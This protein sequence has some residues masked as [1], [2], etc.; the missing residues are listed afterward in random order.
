LI[1]ITGVA[2]LIAVLL[3]R[4]DKRVSKA[5]AKNFKGPRDLPVFGSA[6]EF[7]APNEDLMPILVSV[8]KEFGS[9]FRVWLGNQPYVVLCEGSHVEVRNNIGMRHSTCSVYHVSIIYY[10][11]NNILF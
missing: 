7:L 4:R 3:T 5:F 9:G 1:F 2:F 10:F 11:M 8:C 6:L